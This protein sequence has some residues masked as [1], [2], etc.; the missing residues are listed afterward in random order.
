MAVNEKDNQAD[1]VI[2]RRHLPMRQR[3]KQKKKNPF[4]NC[5]IT[6]F[7]HPH[8]RQAAATRNN[9]WVKDEDIDGYVSICKECW[10]I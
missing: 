6:A 9:L 4:S 1:I 8:Q 10:F 2:M 3:Q 5:Q 7:V